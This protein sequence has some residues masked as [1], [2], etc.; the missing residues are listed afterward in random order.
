MILDK[1]EATISFLSI[2]IL[3]S[4]FF[5]DLFKEGASVSYIFESVSKHSLAVGKDWTRGIMLSL[6][7]SKISLLDLAYFFVY[8][9]LAA[10]TVGSSK[11]LV[12]RS[13]K[14]NSTKVFMIRAFQAIKL[15]DPWSI[16]SG[17]TRGVVITN[18]L[19]YKP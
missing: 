14:S 17:F 16:C 13:S 19:N 9:T 11:F 1:N 6:R 5:K 4:S 2:F 8:A 18:G 12:T 10:T 15:E 3:K 7:D